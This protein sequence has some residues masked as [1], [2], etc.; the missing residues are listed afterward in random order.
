MNAT[1]TYL[2]L[3]AVLLLG[4][5][6]ERQRSP[7][8]NPDIVAI[9]DGV[10]IRRV[11]LA[12]ELTRGRERGQAD[13]QATFDNLL[14]RERLVARARRLNLDQDPEVQRAYKGLLM[15]KLKETELE[16]RIRATGVSED[17]L[18]VVSRQGQPTVSSPQMRLAI[19]RA[20]VSPKASAL[21]RKETATKM[22]AIRAQA[23]QLP[24]GTLGFGPLAFENSDDDS[25]RHR[26]GDLGWL[27]PDPGRYHYDSNVL[28]AGFALRSIGEISS[29][30]RGQD[31]LYLVRLIDRRQAGSAATQ[32][33]E[34]LLRHRAQL[35][36]R[37]SLELAF[38]EETRLMIPVTLNEEIVRQ[39]MNES[40]AQSAAPPS[41]L[42]H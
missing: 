31:G 34:N 42:N 6:C 7:D 29:V 4:T 19:L 8:L 28:A 41:P 22:E 36:K 11:D 38:A 17:E 35:E 10:P 39:V 3:S 24:P 1:S 14:Q 25:T 37:R 20:Q 30:I 15:A 26:G 16:P 23:L 9:V 2:F 40:A 27:N 18:L 12:I 21:K 5:S 32:P 33:D 13:P